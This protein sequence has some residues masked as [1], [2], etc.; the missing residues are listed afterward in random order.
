MRYRFAPIALLMLAWLPVGGQQIAQGSRPSVPEVTAPVL[1]P[2]GLAVSA[3]KHCDE[4][5]GI[6][7]FTATIGGD[8][9]SHAVKIVEASDRRLGAFA[10][11]LVDAQRFTPGAIDGSPVAVAVEL[12]VGLHTCA[13]R[14]K[15][16]VDDNFYRLTL[17]AHPLIALSVTAPAAAQEPASIARKAMPA[18]EQVGGSI[19]APIPTTLIDP[20]IPVSRKLPK[21]GYCLLG[22]TIGADGVPQDVHVVRGLDPELDSNAVDAVKS[23]RFQ[24]ALHGAT[25][26]AVEGTVAATFGYVERE[27]VAFTTFLAERPEKVQA[28]MAS[29]EKKKCELEAINAEE[30]FQRYMPPSRIAGRCLISLTIDTHGVPQNVHIVK[31]LDSGVDT[32]A[33]AMV[34]HLR[35]KPVMD[36]TTPVP[37][38]L[39]IPVRYRERI[40]W[41]DLILNG[42]T[43][44][45][46]LA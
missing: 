1:L 21:R 10:T 6:V 20:E 16:P 18:P 13:Q 24:P 8:G 35:F 34:E 37:V 40:S 19:S 33:V 30:V 27:P 41:R 23:W 43:L 29:H 32:D 38:G 2:S 15:H 17:R 31:G 45:I 7:K 14:E 11:E 5:D 3:P 44:A 9:L 26:V 25:P 22:L 42:L 28:A 4:L 39:V 46:F 12:T 36:G